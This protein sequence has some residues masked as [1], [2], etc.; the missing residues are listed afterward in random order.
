MKEADAEQRAEKPEPP[1]R[2]GERNSPRLLES[3]ASNL[4]VPRGEDPSEEADVI[5]AIVDRDNMWR[6][7]RAVERN[8]GGA[9]VDGMSWEQLRPWLKT[10]WPEIKERLLTGTYRPEA[11]RKVLI[12]K[13]GGSGQRTLGIPTVLDRLIQQATAQVLGPK[14]D[15]HFSDSSYGFRPGRSAHQAVKAMREHVRSGRRWVVDMD[16]EKF[17]DHVNHDVLMARVR[18]KVKDRRVLRLIRR[19]LQAGMMAGGL[20]EPRRQG[21]PQGGPLSPLLSNILLDELDKELERRGHRFCRYAD[22]VN[23]YVHS[24]R[25]GERVLAGLTAW[26][27]RHL[28]L[29]V[30]VAKS[31]VARPWSRVFLGYSLTCHRQARLKVAKESLRRLRQKAK[32]LFRQGRGRNLEWFIREDLN[33]LLRGWSSYFRH[34]E[35]KGALEES[36]QWLRRRLRCMIWRQWKRPRTR[37]RKLRALGLDNTRSAASSSNG[38]GPWW[39]SGASHANAAMPRKFFDLRGL[40]SLLDSVRF[41]ASTS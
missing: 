28:K 13:P 20:V 9:G 26:L 37:R 4:T 12:P 35:V 32:A 22:D 29:K 21:T 15:R 25:A 3:G 6:A 2:R 17:F 16:L 38:R 24:R 5:L 30:N 1:G 11:V 8:R 23:V 41:Y 33:P 40:L 34:S 18:H 39:N 7:L 36:D 10:H 14:F 19:Y 27:G 31:A